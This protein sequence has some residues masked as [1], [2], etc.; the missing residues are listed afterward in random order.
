[1]T[2]EEI[3]AADRPLL[4]AAEVAP[5]LGWDPQWI[6][7]KAREGDLPFRTVCHGTRVQIVRQSFLEFMEVST[8]ESP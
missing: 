8:S 7:I 4:W 1:M 6:R 5:L 2:L 3:R